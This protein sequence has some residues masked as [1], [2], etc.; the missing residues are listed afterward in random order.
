MASYPGYFI[1]SIS[2][3]LT[4]A[5]LG[6]GTQT[7][8]VEGNDPVLGNEATPETI[9]V[10]MTSFTYAGTATVNGVQ[11]FYATRGTEEDKFFFSTSNPGGNKTVNLTPDTPGAGGATFPICFM[12]GTLIATPSGEVAVERLAAGDLVLTADGR[13]LPVRWVGRQTISTLFSD[14]AR[15]Y[16]VRIR[17]G[18]LGDGLPRRDLL[19]SPGHA[20]LVDGVLACAAAL[21]N[22]TSIRREATPPAVFT[23]FHIELA[24]HELVLAEGA[25]AESFV[26]NASREA[27]DNWAEHEAL[28]GNAP[29]QELPLPRAAAPRQLPAATRQ[30]LAAIAAGLAAEVIAAA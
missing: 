2:D 8:T 22:G 3:G 17:A 6:T 19:V 14:P 23:Y 13:T 28:A 20:M 15:S 10:G 7:V 4:A 9:K 27:F 30:R 12:T 25:P 29:I 1:W 24:T 21:V 16:P 11:G 18:A 26:D 5:R